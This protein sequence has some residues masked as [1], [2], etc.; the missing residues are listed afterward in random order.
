[1]EI[2]KIKGVEKDYH[3]G[4]SGFISSLLKKEKKERIAEYWMG[5]HPA[6]EAVT[7]DGEKLSSY[8]MRQSG[9]LNGDKKSLPLLFKVL[10][11]DSPLSL[12]CH[13]DKKQAEEGWK[14]E[15]QNR[16]DGSGDI[17]YQDDNSKAELIVALSPLSV[18]CGFRSLERSIEKLEKIIPQT[19]SKYVSLHSNSI[20]EL[21]LYL[22]DLDGREKKEILEEAEK[23]LE[24][25]KSDYDAGNMD[26]DE[27]ASFALSKYKDD[28]GI[29]F[30]FLMNVV[31]LKKGEGIYL[32]PDIL[33]AYIR[34][35][36][37]ELMDSSD[38]VLRLGLTSKRID[39]K[40]LSRIMVFA[41]YD[42]RIISG[43]KDIFGRISFETESSNFELKELKSG[44]FSIDEKRLSIVLVTE[45]SAQ[46]SY[47]GEKIMLEMGECALIPA[48]LGEY[49]INIDG[50]LFQ[51]VV[52]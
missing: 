19:F 46:F 50:E 39:R 3:W 13:P 49:N 47:K 2:V 29:L 35:N 45:G 42:V 43:R 6:G 31:S 14:R 51:A 25:V 4:N 41:P 23:Y 7:A 1:M 40:E 9:A 36:G 10:S 28:I 48:D 27:I 21:V 30:P 8:I 18:L 5:V 32:K 44:I 37:I 15:E 17:S 12:Q 38:N 11:I 34:G 52:L 16:K 20:R 33:H 24:Y 26:E 22:L